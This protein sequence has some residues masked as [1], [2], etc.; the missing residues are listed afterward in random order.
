[1]ATRGSEEWKANIAAAMR[2]KIAADPTFVPRRNA[3]IEAAWREKV[4]HKKFCK[5]KHLLDYFNTMIE[6]DGYV[7]CRKCRALSVKALYEKRK[8][9][10]A[11]RDEMGL[12]Q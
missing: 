12:L 9:A 5:R 10:K 6:S 7:R 4:L 11:A 1:M 8:A 3:A 2:A